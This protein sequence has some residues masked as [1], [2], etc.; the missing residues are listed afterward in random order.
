VVGRND[1]GYHQLSS[2][3]AFCDVADKVTVRLTEP[4]GQD[5]YEIEGP[6]GLQLAQE[7]MESNLIAKAV[8]LMRH[9]TKLAFAVDMTLWKNLP[10]ASGLGGGSADAAATLRLLNEMLGHPLCQNEL[11]ELALRLGADVPMC[12]D[13][14]A[15]WIAGIGQI[16]APCVTFPDFPILLV[17]PLILLP[18]QGVFERYQ[19]SKVSFDM[20]LEPVEF[21]RPG[22]WIGWLK[23]T[24]N[25]LY[26]SAAHMCPV[27]VDILHALEQTPG[28]LLG[29]LSGSGATCFGLYDSWE[30]LKDA[31]GKIKER[32]PEFWVAC[33]V[34]NL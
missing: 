10:L 13:A 24:H 2:L 19:R 34:L 33:G 5:R 3:V 20:P 15:K 32:F 16:T 8:H 18:T 26:S 31:E 27:V 4:L 29:R 7:S 6:F 11:A 12:L 14:H 21:T 22:D 30:A 17:N 23:T 1:Q 9:T 28:N 25:A